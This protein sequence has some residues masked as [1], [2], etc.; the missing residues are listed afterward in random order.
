MKTLR[1][2]LILPAAALAFVKGAEDY[3]HAAAGKYVG[4]RLQEAS[5]EVEEGL[6][7]YP[8]DP[9]LK[10]LA[11][12]L[13]NMKD[14]QKKDQGQAG[15]QGSDQGKDKDKQDKKDQDNKG[16]GQNQPKQDQDKDKQ[17]QDKKNEQ[18][19]NGKGDQNQD[20]QPQAGKEDED[21]KAG[22][23]S[24]QSM[25]PVKPGQ[26]SKEEAERLLNS[27][28]DDEK[29]EHS[30]MGRKSRKVEVQEDW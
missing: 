2:L 8:D 27:Y 6:R 28:Q 12:Q 21:K 25:A 29:K 16:S 1:F 23:S 19:K 4:S 11:A 10:G 14:Q 20:Q 13:K 5:I 7:H 17:D 3:F 24:G 30:R 26:M 9:R 22:D 15:S 18:D